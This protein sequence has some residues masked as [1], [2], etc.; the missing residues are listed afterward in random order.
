MTVGGRLET[1]M[2]TLVVKHSVADYGSWRTVYDDVAGLRAQHGCTAATVMQ[3][4]GDPNSLL[5]I[6]EFPTLGEAQSFAGDPGLKSA[7]VR[8][9]VVGA[10]SIEFYQ[11]A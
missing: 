3:D 2:A 4:A 5:V 8:G 6:H 7:M 9:G 1:T 11:T 10:P